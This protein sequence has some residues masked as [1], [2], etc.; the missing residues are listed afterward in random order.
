MSHSAAQVWFRRLVVAFLVV[1]GLMINH[2]L[3]ES[4]NSW[5]AV[6][7]RPPGNH[8]STTTS[9]IMYDASAKVGNRIAGDDY[10]SR[11]TTKVNPYLHHIVLKPLRL[12]RRSAKDLFLLIAVLTHPDDV[13]GRSAIRRTWGS[14]AYSNGTWLGQVNVRTVEVVFVLGLRSNV[15]NSTADEA[16]QN[17]IRYFDDI[18]QGDFVDSYKSL[19]LKSLLI[20]QMASALCRR[21]RYLLK[22]DV[23]MFV[24]VPKLVRLLHKQDDG[25]ER[26]RRS[27]L[28]YIISGVG[29]LRSGKYAVTKDE[30]PPD[31][32]PPYAAGSS[33]VISNELSPELYEASDYVRRMPIEDVY[34]TGLLAKVT[35][36]V[37]H[38]K[39]DG[40][41]VN[42][43]F[44]CDLIAD[45]VTTGNHVSA[46]WML[47]VWKHIQHAKKNEC[48][49][50]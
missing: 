13:V 31:D 3:L 2:S 45:R 6:L 32:Y 34:V 47:T 40:F 5:K 49:H 15:F 41:L 20:L 11:R 9:K 26:R 30:Y 42:A 4:S 43:P 37:Y 23:D 18:V 28:G 44:A 16:L 48:A 12:C 7:I 29:P 35:G 1:T 39:L 8:K 36:G 27:I 46:E 17:E 33:Y 38:V 10:F 25:D 50:Y 22:C 19:T 24:N 14:S 21:A